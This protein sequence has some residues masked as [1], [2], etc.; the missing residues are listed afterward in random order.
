LDIL[1]KM[2]LETDEIEKRIKE[3]EITEDTWFSSRPMPDLL[4]MPLLQIGELSA[5]FKTDEPFTTFPNVPWRDIKGF[6]NVVVH[7]YG[8]IDHNVAWNTV[9]DGTAELRSEILENAEVSEAY[10]EETAA[11]SDVDTSDLF[12]LISAL[13][14]ESE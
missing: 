5:H 11:L 13:P 14:D 4:L 10:G 6:R 1:V 8:S 12:D 3:Y 7:G 9:I 2:L